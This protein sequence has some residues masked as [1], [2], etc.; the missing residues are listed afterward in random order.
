MPPKDAY[1]QADERSGQ[2]VRK[3]KA[4]IN[5]IFPPQWFLQGN[6]IARE[7]NPGFIFGTV[8]NFVELLGAKTTWLIEDMERERI[9]AA[10]ATGK[11]IEYTLYLESVSAGSVA[12]WVFVVLPYENAQAWYDGKRSYHGRKAK[13]YYGSTPEELERARLKGC[14][15]NAEL[16]FWIAHGETSLHPPEDVIMTQNKFQPLFNLGTGQPLNASKN[17]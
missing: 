15:V 6:F 5:P 1:R 3:L 2:G 9:K 10:A 17:K 11:K 4:L 8:T 7:K 14:P 16:R 12:Y 13:E